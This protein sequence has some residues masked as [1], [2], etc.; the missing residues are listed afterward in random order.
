MI[1]YNASLLKTTVGRLKADERGTNTIMSSL[2]HCCCRCFDKLEE[3][4]EDGQFVRISIVVVYNVYCERDS[5]LLL[6][7]SLTGPTDLSNRCP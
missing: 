5:Q 1:K 7:G 6:N 3:R 2:E 4:L